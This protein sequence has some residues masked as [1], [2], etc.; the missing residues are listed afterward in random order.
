MMVAEANIRYRASARF[1]DEVDLVAIVTHLGTTS[2]TTA[3]SLERVK[4]GKLLVE[5]DLGTCS[6]TPGRAGRARFP[7][8]YGPRS[9]REREGEDTAQHGGARHEPGHVVAHV[10]AVK[11]PQP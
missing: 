2:M 1:D 3:K 8:R 6:W 9:R 7:T 10:A 5:G 4:N 11:R